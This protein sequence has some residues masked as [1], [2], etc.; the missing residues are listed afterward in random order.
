MPS[1]LIVGKMIFVFSEVTSEWLKG[2]EVYLRSRGCSWN[3]VSTYLRTFRAVYNRA[4]DLQKA[5]YVPHLFRSVYTG[6]R[7]DHK[8]ALGDDDMKKV[9]TKLSCIGCTISGISGAGAIHPDVFA[10]WYAVCR[11]CLFA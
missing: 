8:R 4:V 1:L 5:P 7:A 6:T 2:F 3:T 10:S 11:S 9:F